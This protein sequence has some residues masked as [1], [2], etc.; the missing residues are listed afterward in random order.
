MIGVILLYLRNYKYDRFIVPY[1]FFIATIQLGEYFIWSDIECKNNLNILG[2][3]I[4]I[5]S[6]HLQCFALVYGIYSLDPSLKYDIANINYLY[7]AITILLMINYIYY[8]Y[9]FWYIKDKLCITKY[10]SHLS[11]LITYNF[12]DFIF[13]T[14][15]LILPLLLLIIKNQIMSFTYI[16]YIYFILLLSYYKYSAGK[17]WLSIWCLLGGLIPYIFLVIGFFNK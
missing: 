16:L 10:K 9:T 8:L 2:N 15:Y 6:L 14:M 17:E 3:F 1:V 11:W 13:N 7:S 4:I 12:K 5:T